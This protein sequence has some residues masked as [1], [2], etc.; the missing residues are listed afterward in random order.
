MIERIFKI[1]LF[2]FAIPI[3]VRAADLKLHDTSLL[4]GSWIDTNVLVCEG[5]G[6]QFSLGDAD[7]S[8][9][10]TIDLAIKNLL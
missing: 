8:T 9:I 6:K 10:Y 3:S 4:N 2:T 7:M 5:S 1:C